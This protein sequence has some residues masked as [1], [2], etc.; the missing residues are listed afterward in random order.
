MR[1]PAD[2]SKTFFQSCAI[3][4]FMGPPRP[5]PALPHP[6]EMG[7]DPNLGIL[8]RNPYLEFSSQLLDHLR[9]VGYDDLRPAHLVVF[10]HIDPAGSRI[11][12][13]A[14]RAQMTKPSISYLVE[15]LE[16]RGYLERTDDPSDGRARLVHLTTRGWS[17]ITDALSHIASME[18]E[19]ATAL[20]PRRMSTL[21]RLLQELQKTMEDRRT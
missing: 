18:A 20:G 21:R 8:L 15:Q 6:E 9:T 5:D 4:R 13:L 17:Q 12:D 14:R 19:L 1:D 16:T 3:L 2:I 7:P 10:Q 11:T